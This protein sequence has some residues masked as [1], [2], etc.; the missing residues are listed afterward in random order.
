M[1]IIWGAYSLELVLRIPGWQ[2]ELAHYENLVPMLH[3]G[4]LMA[5]IVWFVFSSVFI[6][7]SYATFR[8]DS[9]AWSTGIIIS[10]IFLAVF[11]LMLASFMI[12]AVLF[13]D[14]FS[15][16]GLVA[17]VL[18]VL[19]DLGIVFFITRPATKLYFE[20]Q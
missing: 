15:V 6:L 10:T 19:I 16:L 18:T 5:T 17:V 9:W 1:F 7:I 3:F 20:I 2:T 11:F 13:L 4:F 12:N 8:K 14:W